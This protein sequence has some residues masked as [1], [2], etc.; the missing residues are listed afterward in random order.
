V[1]TAHFGAAVP[2]FVCIVIVVCINAREYKDRGPASSV[3]NRYLAI[4]V[5][6]GA[7]VVV[8]LVLWALGWRH[9]V[10]GIEAALIALFALFWGIQTKELW[11]EGLR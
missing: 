2:M 3:R 4:A 10:L 8:F 1:E 9:W 6:M 11:R 5:T 7:S